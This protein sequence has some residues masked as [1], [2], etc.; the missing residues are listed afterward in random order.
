ME[1]ASLN[2]GL[3]DDVLVGVDDFYLDWLLSH[4]R[5]LDGP[6]G[7]I[8]VFLVLEFFSER[9]EESVEE[10]F[11]N[12][13]LGLLLN[14]IKLLLINLLFLLEK[15]LVLGLL[16]SLKLG[17]LFLGQE[18]NRSRAPLELQKHLNPCELAKRLTEDVVEADRLVG[19]VKW[20]SLNT[21]NAQVAAS[22]I[23]G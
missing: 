17:D 14:I 4:L 22:L 23:P 7:L 15:L 5:R 13:L 18:T 19:L 6:E 1:A 11:P 9:K 21:P 20:G 2:L 12:L 3:R 10:L 16:L 8:L